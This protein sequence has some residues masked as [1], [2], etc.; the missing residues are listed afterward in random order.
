MDVITASCTTWPKNRPSVD[1]ARRLLLLVPGVIRRCALLAWAGLALAACSDRADAMPDAA[2][3]VAANDAALDSGSADAGRPLLANAGVQFSVDGEHLGLQLT[4]ANIADDA[5]VVAVHFEFDGVPWNE[6]EAGQEPLAEWTARVQQLAASVKALGRPVFLS[7]SMLNGSRRSLAPRARL[8]NG[9][10]T[11]Q[12]NW[13]ANCYDFANAP[14]AAAK[15]A[16]FLRY[17]QRMIAAFSPRWLNY[18]IELN[19]YFEACP[20]GVPGLIAFANQAYDSAK[21]SDANLLAFPSVQIDHLHGY[22]KDSC[23]DASQRSQCFEKALAQVMQLKGDRFAISTYPFLQGTRAAD[24]PSDWFERAAGRLGKIPLIAETGWLSTNIRAQLGAACQTP[25]QSTPE[26]ALAYLDLVLD[27]AT[28]GKLELVTWWSDRDLLPAGLMTNCPCS[29]GA[30]W[31]SVVDV[32]RAAGGADP[33]AAFL[34]E[35]GLKAFGSMGLR[36]YDGNAKP[37]LAHWQGFRL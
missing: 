29:F 15:K 31:C 5:D 16:A 2:A 24:L 17:E 1:T 19:L 21:S 20:A 28:R 27:A 12:D 37:L 13:A 26:E 10:L 34:G 9:K 30:T 14:D 6:L 8:E 18:A 4:A 36:D 33:Q 32:F 22:A 35:L 3:P 25:L 7:I 11:T 23:P